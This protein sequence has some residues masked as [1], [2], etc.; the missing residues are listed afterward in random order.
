MPRALFGE[1]VGRYHDGHGKQQGPENR[2][3]VAAQAV[4]IGLDI[5][6]AD[7]HFG[8]D[9]GQHPNQPLKHHKSSLI[10]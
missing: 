3:D 10:I 5:Y 6:L 1:E 2:V 8:K 7:S 9:R 4:H